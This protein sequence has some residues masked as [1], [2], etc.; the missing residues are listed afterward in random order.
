MS[1]LAQLIST[2]LIRGGAAQAAPPAQPSSVPS[3]PSTAGADP[4]T[5]ATLALA[6]MR[7]VAPA[8]PAAPPRLPWVVPAISFLWIV[9]F[10]G[11]G[12][13]VIVALATGGKT[14]GGGESLLFMAFGLQGAGAIMVLM[15]FFGSSLGSRM[16]D[17]L[18]AR[19]GATIDL[20]VDPI[21]PPVEP[22]TPIVGP[23]PVEPSEPEPKP[24]RLISVAARDMLIKHEVTSREVYE[25]DYQRPTWP[26]GRS[27][28]TIGIGYDVG[29]GVSDKAQL[30]ADW[31]GKLSDAMIKSLERCI[32]VTGKAARALLPRVQSVD[33]PWEAAVAVFDQDTVPRFYEMCERALPNFEEL[34]GDCRGALVSLTY[35]R[36]PSFDRTNDPDGLD[37]YREMRAIKA[38]MAA[39]AW[40]KIPGE[41]R[42]MKRLWEGRG[43]GG[44]LRRREDEAALF[45]RGLRDGSVGDDVVNGEE[46]LALART[47]IG[48]RYVLGARVP[49]DHPNY[50]ADKGMDCAEFVSYLIARLTGRLYGCVDNSA[51]MSSA[52]A[53]TGAFWKDVNK[54]GVA[55]TVEEAAAT[56]GAF[57]LRRPGRSGIGHI[58]ISDGQGGTV[59]AKSTREGIVADRISG[60]RWDIGGLVPWIAY[61]G[62]DPVDVAAPATIYARGQPNMRE[63]KVR[64]IQEALKA[65]G[66]S[67]GDIDGAFGART[68]AAVSTLQRER[69]LVIDG[70]VGPETAAELGI[71]LP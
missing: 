50:P 16:K 1:P 24:E 70:E 54:R 51:P 27:G 9:G 38:H 53:Y 14:F 7:P 69:G 48:G 30:W 19:P 12:A 2:L 34:P 61:D 35:N 41:I 56:P 20:P 57:V 17:G 71:E 4:A 3:P 66:Y 6:Q 18:L 40:E 11:T 33:V 28:V 59:E 68:E 52:D 21:A 15:F 44:L 26:G 29:A 47:Y 23:S 25:R 67:P 58:A 5:L 39:R 43:L 10:L 8:V 64:E 42:S 36:G 31:R 60:R 55:L 63:S 65:A 32:G 45:E 62:H 37:R 46:L 22:V 49:K 13:A